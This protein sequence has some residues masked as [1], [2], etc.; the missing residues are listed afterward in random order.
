MSVYVDPLLPWVKCRR[1]PYDEVSH[2][3]ADTLEEL[4]AMADRLGFR[5]S[6]FQNKPHLPHYDLTSGKRAQAVAYGAVQVDRRFLVNFMNERRAALARES[7]FGG[8]A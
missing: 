4:H 3:F 1:W 5:R 2:M 6:W 8:G 7:L